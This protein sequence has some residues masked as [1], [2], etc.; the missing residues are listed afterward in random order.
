MKAQQQQQ[1]QQE[2]VALEQRDEVETLD[3]VFEHQQEEEDHQR[4]EEDSIYVLMQQLQMKQREEA[5]CDE[6]ECTHGS[7]DPLPDM[8]E[9]FILAFNC[10]YGINHRLLPDEH[11]S[12]GRLQCAAKVRMVRPD[13]LRSIGLLLFGCIDHLV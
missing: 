12:L 11:P 2:V 6:L 7:N 5:A 8:L 10:S 13:V 4:D 1:Q 9:E 3:S